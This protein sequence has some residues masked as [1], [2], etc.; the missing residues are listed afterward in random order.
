[1]SNKLIDQC[2]EW[3]IWLLFFLLMECYLVIKNY[4][5]NKITCKSWWVFAWN[6]GKRGSKML[7]SHEALWK[8]WPLCCSSVNQNTWTLFT[9]S[10]CYSHP[11]LSHLLIYRPP[12]LPPAVSFVRNKLLYKV[13]AVRHRHPPAGFIVPMYL[14]TMA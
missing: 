8:H 3:S 6:R 12:R 2:V 10:S 14:E 5:N 9:N 7:K 13:Y 1:M 11:P 4:N